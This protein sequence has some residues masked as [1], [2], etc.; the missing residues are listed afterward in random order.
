MSHA[1]SVSVGW[2]DLYHT[3]MCLFLPLVSAQIYVRAQFDY[4]PMQDELIPCAQAGV[5]FK[6]GDVLQ[7]STQT[8]LIPGFLGKTSYLSKLFVCIKITFYITK[9]RC[10][11]FQ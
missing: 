4:D 6:T 1:G 5:P 2:A 9:L 8:A 7:V 3:D 10:A 11:H